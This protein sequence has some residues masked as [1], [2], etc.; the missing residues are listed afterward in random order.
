VT[1]YPSQIGGCLRPIATPRGVNPATFAALS[2]AEQM[3]VWCAAQALHDAECW[4]QRASLRVGVVLGAGAECLIDWEEDRYQEGRQLLDPLS[5]PR[6]LAHCIPEVLGLDPD[7]CLV[8][9]VGAACASGNYALAQGRRWLELGW[10]D[11]CLAG[12]CERGVTPMSLACFGNL[13]ALSRRNDEPQRASRPFDRS[14]DGFVLSEGGALFVLEAWE[15]ARRRGARVRACLSGCAATS[16]ACHPIIPSADPQPA[17]RAVGLALQDASVQPEQIDYINAHATSTS[18]GDIA[19]T[20]ALHL[21]LG[22]AV[23]HIPISSTKSMT[24]H[25]LSGAASMDVLA[26]LTALERQAIPPTI[27]L[28]DPDPECD[29]CHVPHQAL[30]HR[31]EVAISNAF[32]FGGSNTCVVLRRVA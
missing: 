30:P 27:N 28:Y 25:L 17:S 4:E 8:A 13:R 3:V 14:R 23:R 29:L 31:V 18:V 11:V 20:R 22:S 9:T 19:E 5:K 26:C 12:G 1:E 16:D 15:Q 21:A 10:V 24:G 2:R 6:G 32:G 7:R